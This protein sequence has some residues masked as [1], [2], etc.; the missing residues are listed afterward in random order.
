MYLDYWNLERKPFENTPDSEFFFFS[1]AH[2]DAYM[3]FKYALSENKGAILL[4]GD[5]GCGKTTLIRLLIAELNSDDEYDFVL[6]NIP[7]GDGKDLLSFILS[8]LG[9][10]DI[11]ERISEI[12]SALGARLIESFSG[13]KNSVVVVDEA[14]LIDNKDTLEELRLLLNF[15]LN[16]RFLINLFLV[17][18]PE[19]SQSM[20][21]MPQLE[22][23]FFTRY[24]LGPLKQSDIEP[25]I[26]HR[27]QVAGNENTIFDEKAIELIWEH[28][29]GVPRLINNLCDL[30]M[31][32]GAL[33]QVKTISEGIIEQATT[34]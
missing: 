12:G 9:E 26:V 34:G 6:L 15:Q 33:S 25:Y 1:S 7:R 4:T 16:D 11:P 18:Q 22:Q 21:D 23:R 30:S 10:E 5:Y 24:H 2:K 32:F 31:L 28:S 20:K 3:R 19:L 14:Q 27:L 8:E 13:G 17:G 29:N